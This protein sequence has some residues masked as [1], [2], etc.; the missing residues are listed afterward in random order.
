MPSVMGMRVFEAEAI[1]YARSQELECAAE[2][3]QASRD[4]VASEPLHDFQSRL[5]SSSHEDAA[6]I[7]DSEGEESPARK[8]P[9]NVVETEAERQREEQRVNKEDTHKCKA[10]CAKL[11]QLMGEG[12]LLSAPCRCAYQTIHDVSK[13]SARQRRGE[14]RFWN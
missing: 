5:Q 8:K 3:L 2:E 4:A 13:R 14:K 1:I 12:D 10:D 7:R 9:R 6:T 11:L